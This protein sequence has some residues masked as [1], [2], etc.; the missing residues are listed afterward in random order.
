VHF[1]FDERLNHIKFDMQSRRDF[2]L[3]YKEAL[4]NIAKYA[5]GKNVWINLSL[6]NNKIELS[7]KDDGKG[8]DLSTVKKGNGLANM[9]KRAD[10]IGG[11]LNIT[12]GV[13]EGSTLH[14]S[15]LRK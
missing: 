3:I 7:I 15:F 14:L 9:Q 1:Y 2:Y 12:S 11:K 10:A 5:E 4:N 13:N 8:F 6:Q